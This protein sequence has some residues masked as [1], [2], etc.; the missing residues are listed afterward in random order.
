MKPLT[1]GKSLVDRTYEILLSAICSGELA[2]GQRINQDGLA[3]ELNIS[4]QPVNQAI[5]LLKN[6]LLLMDTGKRGVI[7]TP[8]DV[9]FLEQ[10]SEF[11]IIVE[12]FASEKLAAVH[13]ADHIQKVFTKILSQGEKALA[14]DN[15]NEIAEYD[16]LFHKTIYQLS[17][18]FAAINAMETNWHH[19]Q[20][21]M[22]KIVSNKQRALDSHNEHIALVEAMSKKDT[23]RIRHIIHN[24]VRVGM[25]IIRDNIETAPHNHE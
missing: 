8:I 10:I 22:H 16:M 20:R 21:A 2:P 25:S 19:I 17:E 15:V 12:V 14:K 9:G 3:A 4:R 24:H 23:I 7:V 6:N 5:V 11:R 13:S 1:P 18:N